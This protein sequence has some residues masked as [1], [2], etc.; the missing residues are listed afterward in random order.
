[1]RALLLSRC[2]L[3]RL[4]LAGQPLGPRRIPARPGCRA[5]AGGHL[6]GEDDADREGLDPLVVAHRSV[7][8][9]AGPAA[10][11]PWVAGN[12]AKEPSMRPLGALY[13]GS[14]WSRPGSCPA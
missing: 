1:I 11:L 9:S 3:D 10:R 6:D 12:D 8:R 7:S 13:G 2:P 4:G 5:R 14:I